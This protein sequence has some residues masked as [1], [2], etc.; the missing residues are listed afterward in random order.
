MLG[1][2]FAGKNLPGADAEQ[3]AL[4][5][6]IAA[7]GSSLL[8]PP[9]NRPP[10][11]GGMYFHTLAALFLSP[12][13]AAP[14]FMRSEA[15]AA[16][17]CQTVL[18]G[19][20]QE[21]HAWTLQAKTNVEYL[22]AEE[23]PSGFIE[24]NPEFF[25]R[26]FSLVKST[27]GAFDDLKAFAAD[28][29]EEI[30][31]LRDDAD[32]VEKLGITTEHPD[33]TKI[34]ED[35]RA[36]VHSAMS[37]LDLWGSLGDKDSRPLAVRLRELADKLAAGGPEPQPSF[38][39]DPPLRARWMTFYS[40]VGQLGAMVQKQ[41]RGAPWTKKEE[42]LFE[43]YKY[44]LGESHGYYGN[45]WET[46]RDD[47][48]RWVDIAEDPNS[49]QMLAAAIGRP[50]ALYVLYPWHGKDV[51]CVGA[52]M[53]YFEYLGTTRLNDKEWKARLDSPEAPKSPGWLKAVAQP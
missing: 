41:L 5:A 25:S 43:S 24:P 8:H 14:D 15:W 10:S 23:T 11:L 30:A 7:A 2:D 16:K 40:L 35:D 6:T 34:S 1:S 39:Q 48:P 3:K 28:K 18:A 38:R 9:R 49:G 51:L 53:P 13:P 36:R 32:F 46:P 33:Q 31:G 12:D 21:R 47:A 22:S 27:M 19:W 52:V 29:D 37:R 17:S 26:F 45:S 42:S 44:I 20:A 50:R 4:Q